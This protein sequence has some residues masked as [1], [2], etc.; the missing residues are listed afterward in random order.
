[1]KKYLLT[2]ATLIG[3]ATTIGYGSVADAAI[4]KPEV[5]AKAAITVDV[6]TGQVI[7]AKNDKQ[8]LPIASV[9]KLIAIYLTERDIAEGKLNPNQA[10]H[11]SEKIAS[12]SQDTS[13]ANVPMSANRTYTVRQLET[14]ALLP[15]SNA[16]AMALTNLVAGSKSEYYQQV[17]QLLASWGIKNV[18]F[19]SASGLRVGDLGAFRQKNLAANLENKLSA[20]E[21]AIVAE[22]LVKAYPHILQITSEQA[23]T[24]PGITGGTVDMQSTDKLLAAPNPYQVQGLKTGTTAYNGVNFVG[25]STVH[26]RP[27]I[28]VVLNSTTGNNFYDTT[29]LLEQ[30]DSETH[31]VSFKPKTSLMVR[32]AAVKEGNVKL[33]AKH[34]QSVFVTEQQVKVPTLASKPKEIS[35]T[36]APL[37][38]NQ[39]VEKQAVRF[40]DRELNDHLGKVKA[41]EY[42]PKHQVYKTNFLVV[43]YRAI[44]AHL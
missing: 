5:T 32:N 7:S 37:K 16:A 10:V 42:A 22:H 33:V 41:I 30:I 2:I 17:E 1:M 35:K 12:F 29:S 31:V 19:Y 43:W 27:I 40:K 20:R 15:S 34:A 26:G 14:A 28:S 38:K 9:S 18:Q 44:K 13:V 21:T 36:S 11:V 8:R 6:Q 39:T 23:A 3:C 25:Y 24:F 4:V